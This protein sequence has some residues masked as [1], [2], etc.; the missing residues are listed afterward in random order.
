MPSVS[1][2]AMRLQRVAIIE[3][4]Q[5]TSGVSTSAAVTAAIHGDSMKCFATTYA[6][7]ASSAMPPSHSV[8][9]PAME[10]SASASSSTNPLASPVGPGI[11]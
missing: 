11:P 4:A 10:L 5:A 2:R 6:H 1:A 7:R 8:A 9:Q 3:P